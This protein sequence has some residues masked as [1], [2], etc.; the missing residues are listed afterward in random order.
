MESLYLPTTF[1][2]IPQSKGT[3][4]NGKKTRPA[5]SVGCTVRADIQEFAG[6]ILGSGTI[7]RR[8]LVMK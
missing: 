3:I 5:R 2:A 1:Q 8:V 4:R 7:F 6:S